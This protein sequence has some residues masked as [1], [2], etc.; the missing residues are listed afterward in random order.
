MT[1]KKRQHYVPKL[2]LRFFSNLGERTHVGLYN[3]RTYIFIQ[4]ASIDG[5]NKE[6]YFYGKES[7]IEDAFSEL[8][9]KTCDIIREIIRTNN[10]PPN[11]SYDYFLLLE[12]V[13]YQQNR[14]KLSALKNENLLN[15]VSQMILKDRFVP[16]KEIA[17]IEIKYEYPALA[18]L[19]VVPELINAVSDLKC[20]LLINRT[21][22]SFITS[23]HPVVK[24]NQF[25][26]QRKYSEPRTG[27]AMKGL[28]LFFPISPNIIL[29]YYDSEIYSLGDENIIV[30]IYD[31]KDI[32]ILN[33]IQSINCHENVFFNQEINETYAKG[34]LIEQNN[35]VKKIIARIQDYCI[36]NK[37]TIYKKNIQFENLIL[38]Q[39]E[40]LSFITENPHVNKFVIS[41]SSDVI[42][43]SSKIDS[44]N[45][46]L[47][48]EIFIE[49]MK[50]R[51][52]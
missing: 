29:A 36:T 12:Y 20:K 32:W 44:E 48:E 41:K 43:P 49:A 1:K 39:I 31:E 42:R 9:T 17:K 26:N 51:F 21:K 10:L 24:W 25:L 30:E 13:M 52:K 3:L 7:D 23:D 19:E 8:E 38:D 2:Y 22:E 18:G 40:T 5:Q 16:T 45:R 4:S 35:I 33:L 28:K 6:D 47:T 14:T 37:L 50:D 27:L 11:D 15:Q 46:K 34:L